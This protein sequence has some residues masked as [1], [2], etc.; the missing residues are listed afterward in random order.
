MMA[1]SQVQDKISAVF[2]LALGF[3]VMDC[4]LPAAWAMCLDIGGAWA[5]AVTGA[6]NSAGQFGGFACSVV[7]GVVVQ[8][9][10]DYNLPVLLI[11]LV[12]GVSALLFWSIDPARPLMP[13]EEDSTWKGASSA[14]RT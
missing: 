11:S 6:M 8:R 9:S 10:G 5:G 14:A 1:A 4:M 3:G 7:F 13:A 12:V 2:L